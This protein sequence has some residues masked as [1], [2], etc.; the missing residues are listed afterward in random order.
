MRAPY[1]VS[2][3]LVIAAA[4]GG[5]G[6]DIDAALDADPTLP[7]ALLQS[8]Q[9]TS[10]TNIATQEVATGLSN[11]VYVTSPPG[12]AR[13]FVL[14]QQGRIRIVKNGQLL[15]TPFLDISQN[16]PNPRVTDSSTEQGLLGLAFHPE[17]ATNNKFY[18]NYSAADS[19]GATVIAQYT[20]NGRTDLANTAERRVLT[21]D[22]FAG[23]HNGGMI[24]FGPDGYL[25]I[26]MGDGGGGDDPEE[27][28]Q[29]NTTLLA[30][31]LRIDVD[32]GAPYGIPESNPFADSANGPDDPRPEIWAI[33]LRN[34]WRWSFDRDTGDL[35]IG[36]VGQGMQEEIDVYGA[37]Q[38]AG[39]NFGWDVIEGTSCH[40]PDPAPDCDGF[41]SVPPVAILQHADGACSVTG[42]Y[43]YRGSCMPDIAGWYFYTDYCD[44]ELRKLEWDDGTVS[45]A[46][47][48][49]GFFGSSIAS[50][51]E[52]ALGELYIVARGDGAVY[53]IV[54]E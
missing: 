38:P 7:D 34:P 42:G 10:G 52:D 51:G 5:G 43:V 26:G 21:I 12:D 9:P 49:A 45:N 3:L 27:N 48:I 31:M 28:G 23:N 11:P 22:Q 41:D 8:C 14:E 35:Y 37:N 24:A 40:E 17:F 39:A 19:G 46:T 15:D 54:P 44:G 4:C 18:V 47:T 13:L 29:D 53:K 33:G 32:A 20:A 6:G 1:F 25:Y 16:G 50:F 36:D 2:L 30:S